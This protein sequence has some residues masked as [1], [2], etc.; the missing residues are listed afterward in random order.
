[1][2]AVFS[3]RLP[4]PLRKGSLRFEAAQ[5][6]PRVLIVD[7]D[8]AA[9]MTAAAALRAIGCT[10][11]EACNGNDGLRSFEADRPQIA[12]LE[13]LTPRIDGFSTCRAMRD[14]EG[15]S[16]AAIVMMADMDRVDSLR[17][18]YEAG[19]T[20]F[21]L[22]PLH[23]T[24]LQHRVRFMYR[25]IL[26]AQNRAR[27]AKNAPLAY[28]DAATG[29]PNRRLLSEYMAKLIALTPHRGA[30]FVIHLE[31]SEG[32]DDTLIGEIGKRV[33]RAFKLEGGSLRRDGVRTD[34]QLLVRRDNDEL[35]FVDPRIESALDATMIGKQLVAAIGSDETLVSATI[36]IALVGAASGGIDELL[37]IAGRR[38]RAT[39]SVIRV[40]CRR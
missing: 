27:E 36:G 4:P 33:L 38:S 28:H 2:N 15:G 22:K 30:V 23:A 18:G 21:V 6:A 8:D 19:A 37:Q 14:L 7:D 5:S 32:S 3:S 11:F 1:M 34:R 9:R 20:D 24:V 25:A 26:A 39:S 12:F 10:V 16:D 31:D 17:I 29:L 13:V 35:V 40:V